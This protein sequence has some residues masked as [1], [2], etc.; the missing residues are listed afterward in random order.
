MNEKIARVKKALEKNNIT[1]FYAESKND[2][3]DIVKEIVP[4]GALVSCGGSVT[5][6]DSGVMEL[7]KSGYYQF[8]DRSAKGVDPDEIYRKTFSCD[9]FF[10]SANAVTEDGVLY[11]VDG[12]SN[13]VAAT[14][15]GPK[16]IVFIIGANKIVEDMAGAVKRVKTVAAPL[17]AKRLGLDTPCAKLG[18]CCVENGGIGTGCSSANRICINFV[19]TAFQRQKDKIKVILCKDN[20]GY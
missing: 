7:L 5:L 18:K 4:Q 9:A 19:A 15:Y 12:R 8:L 13:R 11:N 3:A 16:E 2:I 17:N 6:N 10:T 20:M 14:C 1:V